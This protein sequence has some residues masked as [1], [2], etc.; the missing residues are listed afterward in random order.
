MGKALYNVIWL[1]LDHSN[2]SYVNTFYNVWCTKAITS[3]DTG[4][5]KEEREDTHTE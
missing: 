3:K 5:N 2:N 1:N 4:L